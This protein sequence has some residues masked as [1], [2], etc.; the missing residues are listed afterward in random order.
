MKTGM[1]V[2]LTTHYMEEAAESDY[3][4]VIDH[5]E[6]AA[7]GTPPELKSRYTADTL[8]LAVSEES[9][10]RQAMQDLALNFT[11]VAGEFIIR[12]PDTISAI[13]I[14]ERCKSYIRSFQVLQGSM[15]DAFIGITGREL[16]Q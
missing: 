9:L 1:T 8:R 14:L 13:P 5:G 4:I 3:V 2:F 10:L 12:L 6:I 15:D 11:A 16:R 7:K